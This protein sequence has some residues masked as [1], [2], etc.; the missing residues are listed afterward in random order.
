[1]NARTHTKKKS[2]KTKM[3]VAHTE[4]TLDA[5]GI[6]SALRASGYRITAPRRI[7]IEA[8]L[9]ASAPKS[10]KEIARHTNIKELS[11]IYRTLAELAKEGLVSLLTDGGVAY[12]ELHEQHHDHAIC[13]GC[14]MIAHIP[15][16]VPKV[17][18]IFKEHG[19]TPTTHEIIWRGLC[20]ACTPLQGGNAQRGVI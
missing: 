20:S 2:K 8:L 15:C 11:T 7:L 4:H 5:L 10:A 3:T 17:P 19:F 12:Y 18:G 6:Y 16:S 1:M 9:S 13:D 14:A